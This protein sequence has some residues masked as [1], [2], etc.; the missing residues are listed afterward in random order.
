M[1]G[2]VYDEL[3]VDELRSGDKS[4]GLIALIVQFKVITHIMRIPHHSFILPLFFL[5]QKPSSPGSNTSETAK[6]AIARKA[7][8]PIAHTESRICRKCEKLAPVKCLSLSTKRAELFIK[9]VLA[10]VIISS[11]KVIRKQIVNVEPINCGW[12]LINEVY[13]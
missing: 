2:H 12:N 10:F 4:D 5:P 3:S 11:M 13:L 1:H 8:S 6:I 7:K 9:R